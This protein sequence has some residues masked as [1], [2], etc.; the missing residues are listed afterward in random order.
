MSP[1]GKILYVLDGHGSIIKIQ[2]VLE[3]IQRGYGFNLGFGSAKNDWKRSFNG[4]FWWYV[5]DVEQA[6]SYLLGGQSECCR[7][8]RRKSEHCHHCQGPTDQ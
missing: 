4:R 5:P 2:K 3:F 7:S 1:G 6:R 8:S